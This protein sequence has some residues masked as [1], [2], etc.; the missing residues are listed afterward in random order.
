MTLTPPTRYPPPPKQLDF[1]RIGFLLLQKPRP[2]PHP[3]DDPPEAVSMTTTEQIRRHYRTLVGLRKK[4]RRRRVRAPPPNPGGPA[5]SEGDDV[6]VVSESSPSSAGSDDVEGAESEREQEVRLSPSRAAEEGEEEE[7]VLRLKDPSDNEEDQS[8]EAQDY[9]LRVCDAVQVSPGVQDQLLQ[10]LD[11][12][13]RRRNHGNV[14]AER[15][16]AALR[17]VLQPWPQLLRDFSAFL[18]RDQ[19]QRCGLLTEQQQFE[20]SRRFLRRLG[21]SL[22]GDSA[23]YQQVVSA[24]QRGSAPPPEELHQISSLLGRHSDLQK[25]FWEF[26]Q[27]PSPATTNHHA[28]TDYASQNPPD[29]NRKR[30]EQTGSDG[31][32]E[33][34]E[35][36]ESERPV[37]AKNISMTS[38]G[39]KVVVWT[40]EADRT[41]LT[42][43]QQRGANRKTFRQ[44]SAQLGN[45]TAQQVRGG[46]A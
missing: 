12:V 33:E 7:S 10:V 28:E 20:R 19:A 37:G 26:F 35:E 4:G 1:R 13:S 45:K 14:A 25:E 39:E 5:H 44:I 3:P 9:L 38:S 30:G 2:L 16:Y 42:S 34:E 18:D 6:M 43:C 15:L 31:E 32:R 21:R 8:E 29:G 23:P 36:A 17:R 46:G 40:R 22:G 24:L 41:I 27:Q 11:Q